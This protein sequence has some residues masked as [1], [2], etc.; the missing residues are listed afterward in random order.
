[1]RTLI[2]FIIFINFTSCISHK[3]PDYKTIYNGLNFVLKDINK[4]NN[5][6]F[7][8][9]DSIVY[10]SDYSYSDK[11]LTKLFQKVLIGILSNN[12]RYNH[13]NNYKIC[14]IELQNPKFIKDSSIYIVD[15][16]INKHE[17]IKY[18]FFMENSKL[19]VN[20]LEHHFIHKEGKKLIDIDSTKYDSNYI[21]LQID[22]LPNKN[23]WK[24]K[25][26]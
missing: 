3:Y 19:I 20:M 13:S 1:M 10:S 2:I 17:F 5:N 14:T 23:I 15:F 11:S 7:V 25:G 12:E 24:L 9:C 22:S 26:K 21:P 16:W 6:N 18:E 8:I 4:E